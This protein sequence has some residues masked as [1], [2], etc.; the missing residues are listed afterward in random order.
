MREELKR[1]FIVSF[2]SCSLILDFRFSFSTR[3]F[4]S[5]KEKRKKKK[6]KKRSGSIFNIEDS[7]MLNIEP[8]V[9]PFNMFDEKLISG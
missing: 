9:N 8:T 3:R 1:L 7:S 4:A 5:S 2:T 6:E